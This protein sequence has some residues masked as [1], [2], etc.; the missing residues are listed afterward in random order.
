MTDSQLFD[1]KYWQRPNPLPSIGAPNSDE[2]FKAVG[3]SLSE[4]EMMEDQLAY[5]FCRLVN[6]K[7]SSSFSAAHRAYG[8]IESSHSRREAIKAVAEIFFSHHHTKAEVIKQLQK[9]INAIGMA[10]KRRDD[11]AHGV[12]IAVNINAKSSG[13]FLFPPQYKSDRT[14]AFRPREAD[15][16]TSEKYRYNADNIYEAARKFD[17][18]RGAVI[19]CWKSFGP[20]NLEA[21]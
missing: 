20:L 17:E 1:A 21:D 12:V 8:A 19:D 11:F 13:A 5:L 9:L 10:S 14:Y 7:N 2:V 4:W 6:P 15:A 18:L 3:Y 16:M